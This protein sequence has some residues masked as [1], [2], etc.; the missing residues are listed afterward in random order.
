MKL[1]KRTCG[2]CRH[3][4][5]ACYCRNVGSPLVGMVRADGAFPCAWHRDGDEDEP[6]APP[7]QLL[8][9]GDDM[10]RVCRCIFPRDMP[11][12]AGWTERAAGSYRVILAPARRQRALPYT[13]E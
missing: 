3:R 12:R 7:R 2:N 8:K 10:S 9:R 6:L 5:P 1:E 4:S 11:R 13:Q